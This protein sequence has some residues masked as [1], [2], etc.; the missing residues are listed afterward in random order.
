MRCPLHHPKAS[1]KPTLE[2]RAT[3]REPRAWQ[4]TNS[5]QRHQD[6]EL[7]QMPSH[8]R[9]LLRIP[10]KPRPTIA[11]S[12]VFETNRDQGTKRWQDREARASEFFWERIGDFKMKK[13]MIF[14][15]RKCF[16]KLFCMLITINMRFY[17]ENK[18]AS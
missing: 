5:I 18:E 13:L 10:T 17:L 15:I 8:L 11:L 9:H 4:P 2:R 14:W 3:T 6:L 12:Q 1:T 16:K 7:Q